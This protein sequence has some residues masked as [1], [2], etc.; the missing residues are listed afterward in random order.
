MHLRPKA[1]YEKYLKLLVSLVILVRILI[2]VAKLLGG[3]MEQDFTQSIKTFA[4]QLNFDEAFPTSAF[5]TGRAPDINIDVI[6]NIDIEN[7]NI[8]D[9]DIED[10]D[11][12]DTDI[13]DTDIGDIDTD[14]AD[15]SQK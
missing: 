14:S 4:G 12:E 6:E 1:V 15:Q 2:P 11:I 7:I 13:E 8:Q 5:I 3:D 10:I 9:I